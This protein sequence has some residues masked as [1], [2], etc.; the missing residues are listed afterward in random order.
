M[1]SVTKA[2]AEEFNKMIQT[3]KNPEKKMLRVSFGG[4]G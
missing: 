1:I 3:A 4:Y 2:A